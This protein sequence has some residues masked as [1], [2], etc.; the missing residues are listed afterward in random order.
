MD[1][2]RYKEN[3]SHK[4]FMREYDKSFC[5]CFEQAIKLEYQA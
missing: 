2:N 5:I 3:V 1:Q 4:Q